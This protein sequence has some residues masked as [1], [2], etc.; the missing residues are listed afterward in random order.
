M[1][2]IFRVCNLSVRTRG[3]TLFGIDALDIPTGGTAVIG[4]NDAGKSTLLRALIEQAGQGE[5]MLLGEA[6][7]PQICVDGMAWVG[8]HDRY[9]MSMIVCEYIVLAAF[10]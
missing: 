5:I 8:Q 6:A 10:A 9:N 3:K 1:Q 7:A 2:S 4:S